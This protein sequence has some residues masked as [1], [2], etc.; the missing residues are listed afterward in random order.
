MNVAG[1]N[2]VVCY[3]FQVQIDL[4]IYLTSKIS[5]KNEW[6][7]Y[8]KLHYN[9]KVIDMTKKVLHVPV[10]NFRAGKYKV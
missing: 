9:D 2:P 6:F 3:K 5:N 4:K 10:N 1:S 8:E 7:D